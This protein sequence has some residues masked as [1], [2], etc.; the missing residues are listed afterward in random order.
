MRVL[1]A[2]EEVGQPY[3]VRLVTFTEMKQPAHRVRHPFGQ[4]ATYEEG[5]LVL[6]EPPI[7]A[8]PPYRH[9]AIPYPQT[10]RRSKP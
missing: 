1:W 2:L 8:I 6:S 4:I 9:T 5:D 3:A 7:V 10:T